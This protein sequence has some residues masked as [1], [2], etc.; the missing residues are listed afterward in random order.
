MTSNPAKEQTRS[1]GQIA[2][3]EDV[4]RKPEYKKGWQRTA[5][6]NLDAEVRESWERNPTP[7]NYQ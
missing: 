3:E 2:Y 7:R 4:R 6:K 1:P 5:W